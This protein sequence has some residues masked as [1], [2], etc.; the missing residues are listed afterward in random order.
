MIHPTMTEDLTLPII[1][2]GWNEV[3]DFLER[4]NRTAWLVYFDARLV[5]YSNDA[6]HLSFVDAAKL[7]GA[8][9]FSAARKPHLQIELEAACREVFGVELKIVCE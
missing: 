2:S 3:L 9:D 5:S 6:L 8:H 7:G 1:K 4:N